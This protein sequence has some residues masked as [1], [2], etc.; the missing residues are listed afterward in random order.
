MKFTSTQLFR[1]LSATYADQSY[2]VCFILMLSRRPPL[3]QTGAADYW[4]S[5]GV[6]KSMLVIGM[7]MYGRCLTLQS[8]SRHSV[9]DPISGAGKKGPYTKEAG[10]LAYYEVSKKVALFPCKVQ[11][12]FVLF[13]IVLHPGNT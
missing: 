1:K 9:G 5:L 13:V 4:H 8:P 6:P 3:P 7:P 2:P 11:A 12:N 10:F